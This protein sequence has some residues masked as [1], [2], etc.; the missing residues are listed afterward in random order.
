LGSPAASFGSAG[1]A[2]TLTVAIQR[3]CEWSANPSAAWILVTAGKQGQGD[4]TVSYRVTE[5]VDPVARRG[6]IAVADQSVQIAQGA[7]PCQFSV[8]PLQLNAPGAGGELSVDVRTHTA[9]AWTAASSAPWATLSNSSGNGDGTIRVHVTANSG[10]ARDT[11]L[12][13]AGRRVALAQEARAQTPQ[14]PDPAPNPGPTPTPPQCSY[15]LSTNS[16]SFDADGGTGVVRVR[17]FPGCP[18]TGVSSAVW[19]TLVGVATG[20][21]EAEIRYVVAPN[22]SSLGR[23]AT[24]TIQSEVLRITQDPAEELK[25][26]GR[27]SNVSGSCPDLRFIVD[28]RTV[29]TD[30][31]TEYRHGDCSK[32]RNDAKVTVRGFAQPDGTVRARRVDF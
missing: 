19:L 21:G 26:D 12:I 20:T 15:Q 22:V 1:G 5:N 27:I 31:Q 23:S 30:A 28:N 2:G 24:L 11:D 10:G 17:T 25:L 4:G 29:T 6:S 3:E 13:V 18:W 16:E 8:S 32:A 14:P 9:C 7:A